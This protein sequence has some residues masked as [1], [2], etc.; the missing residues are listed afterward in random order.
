M[1]YIT[2]AIEKAGWDIKTQV[3]AEYS[4]TDGRIIIRGNLVARGKRKR[5]DYMLSY[6]PNMPL[7]IIEA[8]DNKRSMGAGMQQGLDYGNIL[9]IPFIYSSNG[10]GFIEHSQLTGKERELRLDE[11]PSPK[12]LWARYK[13]EKGIQPAQEPVITENY[14][15]DRSGKVPRYYQRVAINRT[16]EAIAKG[17]DRILLVMATGTGKT[18]VWAFDYKKQIKSRDKKLLFL[19]YRIEILGQRLYTLYWRRTY[20]FILYNHK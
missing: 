20:R 13:I 6:K 2:P 5:A 3:R 11:F 14:F 9:D 1:K 7:A 18:I 10:D 16:I 19:S 17:Q 4:F 15:F 12:D 8:K